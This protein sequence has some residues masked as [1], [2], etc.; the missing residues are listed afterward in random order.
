MN[1]P[2][3]KV[4]EIQLSNREQFRDMVLPSFKPAIIKNYLKDWPAIA[5]HKQSPDGLVQYLKGFDVGKKAIAYQADKSIRGH[6]FYQNDLKDVNFK[7]IPMG[8]TESLESLISQIENPQAPTLYTGAVSI[9][10]HLPGFELEN[11]C[12]LAGKTAV[13]RIWFG[14]QA[15]VPTHYDML[16]NIVC[17]IAG[18]RRFTLFPPEQITNLYV[19]PIDFTLS[20]QPISLVSL[21]EPNLERYPK[22]SEAL[23][24]AQVADLEPGD[25]LYIPKLWWHHVESLAPFNVIVNYWWDQNS[26]GQDNPFTTLMHA[27][28]TISQLP[29]AE[30]MAWRAFFDHYIFRENGD[31]AQHIPPE[32]R[33]VLGELTPQTYQT[34]KS[35]VIAS[36][37][38]R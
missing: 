16:D 26:L 9:L 19:G 13:P 21:S 25:A 1:T 10:D 29:K 3:T 14:S 27:L 30:R 24:S 17:I 2:E 32:N 7:R 8:L 31:P 6:F 20:G 23:K 18:R 15:V 11:T 33:G 36:L 28:M 35:Y 5:K 37:K 34:L 38:N 4:C 12:D 22:F